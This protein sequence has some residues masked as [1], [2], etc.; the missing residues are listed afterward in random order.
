[1]SNAV[2]NPADP[3]CIFCK[4]VQG[5]IPCKKVY[6]DDN[7]LAFHDIAPAAPVHVLMIPKKHIV[8]LDTLEPAD[9]AVVGAM[10]IKIPEIAKLVGLKD[11]FRLISNAGRVGRQ[12]VFHLHFHL[13]GGDSPLPLMLP[14]S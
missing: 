5:Q 1:V 13:V 7:M 11:G 12:E 14:R 2:D 9:A 4:I 3:N 6:E 8:S 10:M